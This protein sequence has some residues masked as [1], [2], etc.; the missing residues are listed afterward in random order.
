MSYWILFP[1]VVTF[2]IMLIVLK[3]FYEKYKK[4]AYEAHERKMKEISDWYEGYKIARKEEQIDTFI[5]AMERY[6][7]GKE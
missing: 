5:E 7:K 3:P 2:T 1:M 4:A 6:E